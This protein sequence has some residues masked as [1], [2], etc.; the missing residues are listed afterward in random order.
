MSDRML[1]GFGAVRPD[2]RMPARQ[3]ITATLHAPAASGGL[4]RRIRKLLAGYSDELGLNQDIEVR[5]HTD[6][7]LDRPEL[8]IL[9]R[10]VA[11]GLPAGPDPDAP[12]RA[13]AVV[14][15][16]NRSI[17]RALSALIDPGRALALVTDMVSIG[18]CSRQVA[19]DALCYGLDNGIRLNA[20]ELRRL[21]AR[22]TPEENAATLG[23]RLVDALAPRE[24]VVHA[25]AATARELTAAGADL[26][27]LRQDLFRRTGLEFPD[28]R[29]QF[30][31]LPP[32]RVRLRLNDVTVGE[33]DL[34][35]SAGWDALT[36]LLRR[37]LYEHRAWFVRTSEVK[38]SLITVGDIVPD[39][40]EL[41][42]DCYPLETVSACL[43]ILSADTEA[44]RNLPRLL[45]LMLEAGSSTAD[46]DVVRLAETPL[47]S[48]P[49]RRHLGDPE[50]LA[51][52]IRQR[53]DEDKWRL[54]SD[55]DRPRLIRLPARLEE[56]LSHSGGRG[57]AGRT[58]RTFLRQVGTGP[59]VVVTR[60][61]AA[62]GPARAMLAATPAAPAVKWVNE[63]PPAVALPSRLRRKRS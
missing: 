42:E 49:A 28:V 31:E 23:E 29:L 53:L 16:V 51:A 1:P 17:S 18:T 39:M 26:T 20:G 50:I 38:E 40:V 33:P 12:D 32:G 8:D 43:R 54:G 21:I 14:Q 7:A 2:P 59:A 9:D 37:E 22:S 44:M 41:I 19:R 62:V 3:R 52:E 48:R 47:L 61:A 13:D 57:A 11:V 45:W 25:S 46:P 24:I 5:V 6:P 58:A 36:D 4:V 35:Q 55:T 56:Q 34:P 30:A 27:P 63:I 60:T 10:P 15:A